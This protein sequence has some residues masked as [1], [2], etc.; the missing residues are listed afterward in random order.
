V[1]GVGG[2]APGVRVGAQPLGGAGAEGRADAAFAEALAEDPG[3]T[4]ALD[5]LA[6]AAYRGG[7]S[8]RAHGLYE[9][10]RPDASTLGA[11][12]VWLRRG[13]LREAVGRTAEAQTA[14]GLAAQADPSLLAAHEARARLSLLTADLTAAMQALEALVDQLPVD[15]LDRLV[16][17]RQQLGEL[18]Q[19]IGDTAAA[20]R[21]FEQV[22]ADEPNR[23]SALLPMVEIYGSAGEWN[24]AADTLATLARLSPA[25][26]RR[27]ELLYRM[28]E[29]ARV[30]LG[31]DERAGDAYLKAI[32]LDASHVP[33]LRRLLDVYWQDGD[34]GQLSEI[35][36]E[37]ES[38][39]ALVDVE[40]PAESLARVGVLSAIMG[41]DRRASLIGRYLGDA[42]AGPVA[43]ALA[44]RAARR[45]EHTVALVRA[46]RQLCV[47][48]GPALGAVKAVLGARGHSDPL[49]RELAAAM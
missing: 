28:G 47:P 46:A 2:E 12:V 34:D 39:A 36:S 29:I 1:A 40:T 10:L 41:D 23:A 14:Y 4:A 24:L 27:A 16:A 11:A 15:D 19:R 32:D 6:D 25:P 21:W 13:E 5:A 31:D 30:H 49:A 45:R 43:A 37:L 3:H 33:T 17:L 8:E 44:E 42:G 18:S 9:Q 26:A 7:Q 48:P 22:L 20:R 35:A 38:R